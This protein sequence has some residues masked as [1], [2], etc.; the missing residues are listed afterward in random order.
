MIQHIKKIIQPLI[1]RL[2][3]S[4]YAVPRWYDYQGL[5][6]RILPTVFHPGWFYSTKTLLDFIALRD[7]KNKK[8]LELGAGSGLI[9]VYASRQGAEC[10]ASDINP[11]AIKAIYESQFKNNVRLHLIESDLFDNIPLQKFDYILINP[12]Y[13]PKDPKDSWD[14]AFYCGDHFEYFH[15]LYSQIK[16]FLFETTTPYMILNEYC[17][18]A[19]I[20]SIASH[21]GIQLELTQSKSVYAEKQY[22]FKLVNLKE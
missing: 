13:F 21:Y 5:H 19:A 1:W 2:Y 22:I 11:I 6:I 12:P 9:S 7:L 20:E 4:Y 8:I 10:T 3:K 14:Q 16:A 17:N 18:L 15:K